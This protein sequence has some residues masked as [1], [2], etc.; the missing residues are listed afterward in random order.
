MTELDLM[1]ILY[2]FSILPKEN[3][4]M[5][6]WIRSVAMQQ[7]HHQQQHQIR[8]AQQLNGL[9]CMGPIKTPGTVG[10][11][12]KKEFICKYCNRKFTKSYNLQIHE[13]THTGEKP[14]PCNVCQK[15]FRRQDHLR[16][17]KYTHS[18][19]KPFKC[20]QCGK[21][22]CQSRTLTIHKA[23]HTSEAYINKSFEK[24]QLNAKTEISNHEENHNNNSM[25]SNDDLDKAENEKN[26][27]FKK[28]CP[29][30]ENPSNKRRKCLG[31]SIDEIIM[32]R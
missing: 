14:F 29:E 20:D 2:F 7:H 19:D 27:S 3:P 11:R 4:S 21:G 32:Q 28:N 8:F 26:Q 5:N 25:A 16:D 22:F 13:R 9:I 12:S 1:T 30:N 24:Q 23:I 31:F 15:S 17:H 6:Q 10:V 18:T